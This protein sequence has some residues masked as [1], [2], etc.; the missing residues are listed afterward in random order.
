MQTGFSEV[1]IVDSSIKYRITLVKIFETFVYPCSIL[2][3]LILAFYFLSLPKNAFSRSVA[4][5]SLRATAVQY[6]CGGVTRSAHARSD[7]LYIE[8]F[9]QLHVGPTVQW[10][11]VTQHVRDT[12]CG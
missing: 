10:L 9:A 3:F 6:V 1:C 2:T 4:Y 7:V 12:P 5:S 11:R 8:A